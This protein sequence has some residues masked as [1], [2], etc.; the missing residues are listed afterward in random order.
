MFIGLYH[1]YGCTPFLE[2]FKCLKE[3]NPDGDYL[4]NKYREL[5][6]RHLDDV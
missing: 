1:K 6:R 3:K 5:D 2:Y 4:F